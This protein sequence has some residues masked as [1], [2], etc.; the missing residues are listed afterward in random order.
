MIK[1]LLTLGL[2]LVFGLLVFNYFWGTKEDKENV[3]NI[4]QGIKNLYDS[5]K[6]KYEKG[7]YDNALKKMGDVFSKLKDVVKEKGG[8]FEDRLESLEERKRVLEEQLDKLDDS[9]NQNSLVPI[10]NAEKEKEVR[11]ELSDLIKEIDELTTDLEK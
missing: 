10:D 9:K 2:F 8:E 4:T 5:T 6:D 11:Q 1:R 3:R 7:Q